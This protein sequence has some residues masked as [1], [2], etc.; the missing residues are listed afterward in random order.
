MATQTVNP[1]QF[2]DAPEPDALSQAPDFNPRE[3]SAFIDQEL[4]EW[5]EPSDD[6]DEA[7]DEHQELDAEYDNIEVD[8]EDWEVAEGGKQ[9]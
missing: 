3:G 1:G 2:D 9:P 7:Q 8:D 4:L 6:E 5:S